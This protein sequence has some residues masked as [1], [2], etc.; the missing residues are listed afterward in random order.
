MSSS[1]ATD[2]PLNDPAPPALQALAAKAAQRRQAGL[3]YAGEVSV[4][5]A[6]AFL[7][8]EGGL[9]V[10]VRTVPEWQFVGVP[11]LSATKGRLASICWKLY[12]D[13]STNPRFADQLATVPGVQARSP[14]FF[15]C[16]SGGRSLDAAIA[17]TAQGYTHCF[18]VTDGF[19]GEPDASGKRGM[20]GGWKAK[21][22]PWKQG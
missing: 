8:A 10:D 17:M 4:E 9:L 14:L 3:L 12:P 5:E 18:S 20:S 2:M 22:L 1:F 6:Y 13:F 7:Q 11:D 19:E 15:L 21:N 16:R